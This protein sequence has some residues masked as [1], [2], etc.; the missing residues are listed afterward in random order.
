MCVCFVWILLYIFI[1]YRSLSYCQEY[2]CFSTASFSLLIFSVN[3]LCI[4]SMQDLYIGTGAIGA[5][6]ICFYNYFL[7]SVHN[8]L[9]KE[10]RTHL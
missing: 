4:L 1:S 9:V 10:F 2:E 7:N 6:C 3:K 8:V 5:G